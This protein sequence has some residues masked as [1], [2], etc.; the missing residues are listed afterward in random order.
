METIT[1]YSSDVCP[2]AQRV[3]IALEEAKA[4]Y[5]TYEVDPMDKPEWYVPKVNP[6]TGKIPA[7]IYGPNTDP[8]NPHPESAKLTESL[9]LLEFI[10]DLYPTSG[11]LSPNPVQ[12]AHTRFIIDVF[13]TKVFD[14]FY[15]TLWK[16]TSPEGLYTGLEALQTQLELR[17]GSG[18]YLGGEKINIADAAM[19]PFL[20]RMEAHYRA[21]VGGWSQGEGPKI[22]AEIFGSERFRTLQR[23]VQALL[24]RDTV[25]S[26]FLE[27]KYLGRVK[28][29]LESMKAKA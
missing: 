3:I 21:D 24:A 17:L 16:G 2:S 20:A 25:K 15:A 10:A 29:Y 9:V 11:L 26:S 13:M 18:P 6:A 23:Y 1:L 7:M 22:H 4:E 5:V 27:E 8:T 19:A 12:R 28:A 14:A